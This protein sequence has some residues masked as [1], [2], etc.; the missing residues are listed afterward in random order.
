MFNNIQKII[1][2]KPFLISLIIVCMMF[3]SLGV[4]TNHAYAVNLNESDEMGLKTDVED[5]LENSQKNDAMQV[6]NH[7]NCIL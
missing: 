7:E 1:I 3:M 2:S 4:D 6:T 5:K